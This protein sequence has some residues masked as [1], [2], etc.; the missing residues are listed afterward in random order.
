MKKLTDYEIEERAA[1]ARAFLNSPLC[2]ALFDELQQ[3]CLTQF[4]QADVGDLTAARAHGIIKALEAIR[5][6]LQSYVDAKTIRHKL[7]R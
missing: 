1:E 4:I 2:A 3:E 5:G 6:K 7:G